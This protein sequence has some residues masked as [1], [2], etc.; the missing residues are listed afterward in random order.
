MEF[1]D[2]RHVQ[3]NAK[4]QFQIWTPKNVSFKAMAFLNKSFTQIMPISIVFTSWLRRIFKREG[5]KF[6]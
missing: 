3:K 5:R 4:E 1:Q 6:L 2:L